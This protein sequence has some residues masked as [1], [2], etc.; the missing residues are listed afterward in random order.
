MFFFPSMRLG[1]LIFSGGLTVLFWV[2]ALVLLILAVRALFGLFNVGS[3]RTNTPATTTTPPNSALQILQE[4]F[5]RGE[6][7]KDDYDNM[8]Q[9]LTN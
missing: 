8:R 7:S 6:I 4:R 1:W 5:A 9:V 3:S 2:V